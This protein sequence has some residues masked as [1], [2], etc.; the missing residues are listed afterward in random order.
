MIVAGINLLI[1]GVLILT[2]GLINPKW[3]LVWIDK[4]GRLPIVMLASVVFMIGLTL[5]GEGTK[6]KQRAL[7]QQEVSQ[8]AEEA[9]S[10][11]AKK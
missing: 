9:P 8:Q 5:F 6:Q 2:I 7:A 3:L 4:P 1:I 10:V 11:E